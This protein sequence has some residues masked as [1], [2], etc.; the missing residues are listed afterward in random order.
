MPSPRQPHWEVAMHTLRHIKSSP[1][2]GIHMNTESVFKL[3]AFC[4]SDWASCLNSR[5]S[6][7]G[8]FIILGGSPLS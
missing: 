6:V 8:F 5:Q 1:S 4:D 7:N 2:Q 3:T